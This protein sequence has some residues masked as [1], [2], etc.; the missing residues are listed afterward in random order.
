M[1]HTVFKNLVRCVLL[2]L[3]LFAMGRTAQAE[4]ARGVVFDDRNGNAIRDEGEPGLAGVYVSNGLEIIATDDQ[5]HYQLPIDDDTI[6]FVIKPRDWKTRI[7]E[8]NIPRFYFIH[9]PAGSPDEEFTYAGVEP[10]GPLPESIDFPLTSSPEPDEFTV[11]VMGDP[12]PTSREEVRFY[13]NDVIAELV[14]SSAAFGISMGDVVGDDLSLFGAVNAVQGVV[15]I[16]WRNV[17]GNH[18]INRRSHN[19]KYSDETFERVY[20]PANYVFQF[21]AVHFIVLDNV[22]WHGPERRG[23]QGG[24]E[25]RL[26]ERQLQFVENYLRLVPREERVAVCTHIPLPEILDWD[27]KHRTPQYRKLLEILSNHPHTMSFSAHTHF[28]HQDFAGSEDGYAPAEGTEHHH[29][30]VATASGSW[31]RGPLDEQGFPVTT[32]ADGAPNGYI[33]ATFKGHDY[34]LRYKAARMRDDFQMLVHAPSVI[35]VENT[36]G[37]EILA[38]IFN[39]NEKS[40]VQMRIRGQGGWIAMQKTLRKDPVFAEAGERSRNADLE[41]RRPLPQPAITAHIWVAQLPAIRTPGVYVLEV[42]ATDMFGQEDRGIR[43]VEVE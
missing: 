14:D 7:D 22:H 5:G 1:N 31:Y 42:Q 25:G 35:A 41:G 19:D 12:Q 29:H 18:D 2:L 9:K 36:A 15:G 37:T 16:P 24:Y 21:G 38:N 27:S 43:L 33:L 20:G 8:Q 39:G 4:T 23:E 13:A 28:N 3:A 40:K 17:L 34:R 30:N 32:M 6:V 26:S 11:I 10:T